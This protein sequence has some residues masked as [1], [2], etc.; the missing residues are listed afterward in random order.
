MV[1]KLSNKTVHAPIAAAARPLP[2]SL[3]L[4]G[5]AAEIGRRVAPGASGITYTPQYA[6]ATPSPDAPMI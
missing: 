5:S 6:L 1:N 2:R 4:A 3:S